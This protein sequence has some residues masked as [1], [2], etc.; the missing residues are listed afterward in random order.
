MQRSLSILAILILLYS[1]TI[2]AEVFGAQSDT[3]NE[4]E[5]DDYLAVE[6]T[7]RNEVGSL[8]AALEVFHVS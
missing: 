5:S 4:T 8:V 2:I 6:F 7:L 1:T 3:E